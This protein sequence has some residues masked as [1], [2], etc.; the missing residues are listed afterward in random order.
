MASKHCRCT[1]SVQKFHQKHSK[2]DCSYIDAYYT[3]QKS[4]DPESRNRMYQFLRCLGHTYDDALKT[5]NEYHETDVHGNFLIK[6]MD[7]M[8]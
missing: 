4:K 2:Q 8:Q 7:H 6:K 1:G 5:A 3:F